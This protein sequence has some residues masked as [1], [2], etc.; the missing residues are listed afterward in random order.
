MSK[1]HFF[2]RHDADSLIILKGRLIKDDISFALDT[3]ASHTVIDLTQLLIAGFEV[4]NAVG[5]VEMETAKGVLEAYLFRL[6]SLTVLG[7]T[8]KNVE[9]CSYDF[10]S[11]HIF[12]DFDG[13][14]G[15]DFLEDKKICIDFRESCIT[16]N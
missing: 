11:N 12:T 10:F 6:P 14:L 5:T 16:V 9:I 3:G 7:I 13:V 4:K 8:R 1:Q 15:L 2:K